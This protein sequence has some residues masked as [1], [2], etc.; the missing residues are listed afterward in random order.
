MQRRGNGAHMRARVKGCDQLFVAILSSKK[1]DNQLSGLYIY[2]DFIG[3][4]VEPYQNPQREAN[5]QHAA[6]VYW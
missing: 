1:A 5:N 6:L 3:F 2:W 4:L